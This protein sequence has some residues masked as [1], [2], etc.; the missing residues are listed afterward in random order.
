MT[1]AIRGVLGESVSWSDAR[2]GSGAKKCSRP[3][4][5]KKC[6]EMDIPLKPAEGN[7]PVY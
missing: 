3:P 6:K 5:P 7:S 2:K 1:S 4:E